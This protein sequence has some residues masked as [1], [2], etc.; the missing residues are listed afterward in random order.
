MVTE[1]SREAVVIEYIDGELTIF[2]APLGVIT[3]APNYDWHID[4]LKNYLNLSAVALPEVELE[5]QS[6]APLGVGSGMI[7]LLG[8]LLLIRALFVRSHLLKQH[9]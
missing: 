7:G 5:G 6:F 3:N 8:T 4:K 2:D 9:A 1:P